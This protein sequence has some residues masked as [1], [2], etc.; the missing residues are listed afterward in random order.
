MTQEQEYA[1]VRLV[2]Q[3]ANDPQIGHQGMAKDIKKLLAYLES[4]RGRA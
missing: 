1:L 2:V 4:E 3:L